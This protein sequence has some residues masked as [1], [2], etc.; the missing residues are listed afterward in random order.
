MTGS[1][2]A[3]RKGQPPLTA[4]ELERQEILNEMKKK[5]ALLTDSSWIRQRSAN[6]VANKEADMPTMR[7]YL[8]YQPCLC[9]HGA[10]F[11]N[12]TGVD[13]IMTLIS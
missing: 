5:N 4:A 7:R 2:P 9:G 11:T 8:H 6:I 10:G 1:G 13:L 12:V 3:D